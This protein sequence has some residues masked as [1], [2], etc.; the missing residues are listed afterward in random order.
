MSQPRV[1]A[2]GTRGEEEDGDE[3]PRA[4][5]GGGEE[6][7]EEREDEE[8]ESEIGE[9]ARVKKAMT[10]VKPSQ[11]E[12]D[13]HEL[14]H[15]NYRS[16]CIHCNKGKARN[17]PRRRQTEEEDP[18]TSKPIVSLDYFYMETDYRH[19]RADQY[20]SETDGKRP[21]LAVC[22]SRTR[23][24]FAHDMKEKGANEETIRQIEEDIK[25]MGY[26]GMSIIIKGDQEP[27]VIAIQEAIA[28]RSQDGQTVLGNRPVG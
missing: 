22:D 13:E 1:I 12:I 15:V 4:Q 20:K 2:A 6:D 17:S 10:P 21:I 26:E 19:K 7:R 18:L 24:I 9:P 23:A 16:W 28:R 8:M 27:S 14:T 3:T 25:N 11:K 5:S